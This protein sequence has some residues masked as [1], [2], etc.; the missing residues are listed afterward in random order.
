M[1][2]LPI[3]IPES[4]YPFPIFLLTR[5]TKNPIGPT[6]DVSKFSPGFMLQMDFEFFSVD[7][8]CGFISTFVAIC[9]ATS[10]PFRF[11]PRRKH[12]SLGILIILV[13]KLRK[14]DKKVAFI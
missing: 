1:E 3:N 13:A 9:S 5:T 14:Q 12:P 6:I 2:G 10:Y 8:I 7:S 11:T 4:E